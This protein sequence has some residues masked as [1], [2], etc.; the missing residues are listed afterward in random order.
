LAASDASPVR[1]I[2]P[3]LTGIACLVLGW[4][5]QACGGS[6]APPAPSS[7]PPVTGSHSISGILISNQTRAPIAGATLTLL[8]GG[9]TTSTVTSG[10]AGD[11][12]FAS[13]PVDRLQLSI[14]AP[15]YLDRVTSI[16]VTGSRS[17][18]VIDAISIAPPFSLDFYRQFARDA[19]D[20]PGLTRL[21]PWSTNPSFYVRSVV[22]DSGEIVPPDIID[23][24]RRI[25]LNAVPELSAGTLRLAAFEV[26]EEHRDR[27][28]GWVTVT[29]H[30][31]LSHPGNATVGPALQGGSIRLRFD[32]EL[33]DQG[34]GNP[35]RCESAMVSVADH[36]IVHTMGYFHTDS[37]YFDFHSGAGCP[38]AGRPERVRYHAAVMY[39]RAKGNRDP[40]RDPVTFVIPARAGEASTAVS[41]PAHLF[42]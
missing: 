6:A 18:L 33:D 29:F 1:R 2:L 34:G 28:A 16:Q 27:R 32:P 3:H 8:G 10:P 35:L 20:T 25:F 24:L 36:E 15:G 4:T 37:S 42:R 5:A 14:S 31:V 30:R 22:E 40:D 19:H 26:G 12:T 39:S 11:F 21:N 9:P 41:C 17:D 13:V 23:A 7:V 38:G